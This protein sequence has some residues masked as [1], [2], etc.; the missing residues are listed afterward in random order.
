ME[1]LLITTVR[2]LV[3][4]HHRP[5]ALRGEQLL[6]AAQSGI[7]ANVQIEPPVGTLSAV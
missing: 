2:R 5:E 3:T 6:A 1:Y 7:S 4:V